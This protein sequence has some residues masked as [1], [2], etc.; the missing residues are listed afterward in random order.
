M[1]LMASVYTPSLTTPFN[2][3]FCA[4][5]LVHSVVPIGVIACASGSVL[6]AL[7]LSLPASPVLLL[8]LCRYASLSQTLRVQGTYA[9]QPFDVQVAGCRAGAGC[10]AWLL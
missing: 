1:N 2:W 9:Q 3:F 6:P 7:L 5:C 4:V 8:L 10:S